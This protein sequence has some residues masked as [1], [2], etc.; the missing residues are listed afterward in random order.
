VPL[1]GTIRE[2]EPDKLAASVDAF[3][4][5]VVEAGAHTVGDP[6]E[7]DPFGPGVRPS[8]ESP[9]IEWLLSDDTAARKEAYRSAV[10]KARTNA[11]SISKEIGW[12]TLKI[13]SVVDSE[14]FPRDASGATLRTPAGQVA[15]TARVT[16]TCS[17]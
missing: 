8:S 13:V 16:L 17:R 12:E 10:R 6:I 5:K 1:T 14:S 9:R 7:T 2:T 4:K 11:E 15:V 3:L